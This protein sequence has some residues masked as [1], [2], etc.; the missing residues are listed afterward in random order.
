[1]SQFKMTVSSTNQWE[2]MCTPDLLT[3]VTTGLISILL[4]DAMN[5]M[6][7]IQTGSEP[8]MILGWNLMTPW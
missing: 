2:S 8:K 4:E 6:R 3:L 5:L 1:M 7:K